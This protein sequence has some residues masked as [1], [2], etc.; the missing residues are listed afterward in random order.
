MP[1]RV[2]FSTIADLTQMAEYDLGKIE[3]T[4]S[5]PVVGS[6]VMHSNSW[7]GYL[8]TAGTSGVSYMSGD[9]PSNAK[10]LCSGPWTL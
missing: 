10:D 2:H 9:D 8:D 6:Q 5:S 3:V 1:G 7:H 4:G